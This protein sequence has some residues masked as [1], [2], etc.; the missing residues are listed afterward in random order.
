MNDYKKKVII[1]VI[2]IISY[3]IL[4]IL[5]LAY[6]M[7]LGYF[8]HGFLRGGESFGVPYFIVFSLVLLYTMFTRKKIKYYLIGLLI[9]YTLAVIGFTEY[10]D[11]LSSGQATTS[12]WYKQ[13]YK[14]DGIDIVYNWFVIGWAAANIIFLITT[15]NWLNK[16]KNKQVKHE[17]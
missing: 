6:A 2:K 14:E 7:K 5:A 9:I 13:M 15:F 1:I 10:M 8:L 11:Y 16:R 4:I 12:L 17:N 3:I